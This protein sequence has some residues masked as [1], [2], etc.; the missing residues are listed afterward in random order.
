MQA[1]ILP[2]RRQAAGAKGAEMTIRLA[3]KDGSK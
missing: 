2:A 1:Q 3:G